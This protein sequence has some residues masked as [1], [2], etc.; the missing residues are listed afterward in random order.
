MGNWDLTGKDPIR[1]SIAKGKDPTTW[2]PW[3]GE[4]WSILGMLNT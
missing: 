3:M 4:N 2:R 1:L